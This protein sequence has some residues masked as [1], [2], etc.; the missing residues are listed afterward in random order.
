MSALSEELTGYV[1]GDHLTITRSVTGLAAAMTKAWLTVKRHEREPDSDARLQ[2]VI[3]TEDVPG[4]GQIVDAGGAGETGN[5]RFDL[6]SE[7]TAGLGDKVSVYDIQIKEATGK[8]NTLEKG[9]IQLT[10][11]VTAA[12]S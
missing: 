5:L 10:A 2:K 8:I 4:T 7:D 11:G 12:S 6:T 1:A 9:T 3:T